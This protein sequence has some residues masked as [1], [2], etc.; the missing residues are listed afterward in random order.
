MNN[1]RLVIDLTPDGQLAAALARAE[2][3]ERERDDANIEA[4]LEQAN[5]REAWER[6]AELEAQLA[7]QQWRPATEWRPIVGPPP[8]D[9][10]ELKIICEVADDGT[11]YNAQ[12]GATITYWTPR[13]DKTWRP[14]PPTHEELQ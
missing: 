6:V 14:I 3:A 8:A 2:A 5:A 13:S 10:F 9:A 4:A 7:A 12:T 1:R 11:I